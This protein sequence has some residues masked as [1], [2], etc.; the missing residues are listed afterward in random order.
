M[1]YANNKIILIIKIPLTPM[2]NLALKFA[3]N[4]LI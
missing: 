4:Q 3:A 1:L 2:F